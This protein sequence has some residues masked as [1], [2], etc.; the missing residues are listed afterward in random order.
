MRKLRRASKTEPTTALINI[1]FLILIFFMVTGTLDNQNTG[2]V[3]FVQ[4]QEL[5]CCVPPNAILIDAQGVTSVDGEMVPDITLRLD[6]LRTKGDTI[7]LLP[8]QNLPASEL[9]SII[10]RLKSAGAGRIIIVTEHSGQ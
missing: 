5:E 4:S 10:G 2:D 1:V 8:D 6:E 7:R 9:L 3:E